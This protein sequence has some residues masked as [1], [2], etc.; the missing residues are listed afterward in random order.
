MDDVPY[1]VDQGG[2]KFLLGDPIT[3]LGRS[4]NCGVFMPERR[5]SRRHAEIHWDGECCTLTDLASAN[6]TF[7]NGRRVTGTH[8]L[9]D[10]DEIAIAS[11]VFAFHDPASTLRNLKFPLLVVDTTCG[12]IWVNRKPVS[13]SPKEQTLFDLLYQ[14]AGRPC[15]KQ[16]I[17]QAVWPEYQ[18]EVYDY[19]IES[20]VKRL[21]EKLEPDPANPVLILTIHG[22][23]YKLSDK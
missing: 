6:G 17:A 15:S 2:R 1:L 22:R 4:P 13:L 16:Q 23:G 20:L 11:A 8:K 5:A 10:G 3:S 9:A 7:V 21:R 18:A 12:E 14:N 19:Q